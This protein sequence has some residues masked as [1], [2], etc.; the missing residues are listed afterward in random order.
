M[1]LAPP[2]ARG[3]DVR[4]DRVKRDDFARSG[5]ERCGTLAAALDGADIVLSLVTADQALAAARDAAAHLASGAWWADMNSVAPDTKR[6]A[7]Q[8]I[9][10]V[11]GR[12]LDVAVMAPVLPAR[13]GVPLLVAGGQAEAGAAALRRIGFGNVRAIAE[14]VGTA[15][16]IKMIRSVMVKGIEALSVECTLAANAAG[17]LPEVIASLDTSWPGADWARRFD[18][19]LDRVMRHGTRRAAEMHEVVATLEALGSGSTLSLATAD[20]QAAVGRPGGAVPVGLAAKI[21][22]VRDMSRAAA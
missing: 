5:I 3:F 8:V 22:R 1:A 13:S 12:Y 21:A 9:T 18:H 20:V 4:S 14:D 17:V 19:H 7:Q 2:G 10:A 11:G 6:A 15:A 16:A